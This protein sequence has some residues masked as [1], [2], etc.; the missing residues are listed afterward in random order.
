MTDRNQGEGDKVSAKIYNEKT[1]EF[2]KSGRVE[3]AARDAKK[4]LEGKERDE[5][6]SAEAK[7][8]SRAREEDPQ[9]KR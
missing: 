2:A 8:K 5:L 1:T 4:A 6:T 7:G 9:V 3:S